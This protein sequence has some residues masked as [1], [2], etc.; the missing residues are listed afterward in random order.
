MRSILAILVG[1]GLILAGLHQL[2]DL[3]QVPTF[4]AV[5]LVLFGAVLIY[6]GAYHG[7]LRF[8]RRR[9]YTGGRERQ[10]IARLLNPLDED[11][12]T[13]L[14]TFANRHSEWLMSVDRSSIKQVE[15]GLGDGV[16][17]RAY[18]GDD[19][20]IYALDIGTVKV[21][22]ISVGVPYDGKLR[23][24]VE[25]VEVKKREWAERKARD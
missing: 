11:D 9:A 10:G 19:D 23:A 24:K 2:P 17:A 20:R 14:I 4:L 22:P 15:A 21:L 16:P 25:R 12:I 3:E 13:A 8:Q 7:W 18:L 6:G 5:I 1:L